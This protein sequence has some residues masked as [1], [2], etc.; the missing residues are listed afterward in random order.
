M[1]LLPEKNWDEPD[2]LADWAEVSALAGAE[3]TY[4]A[5][6]EDLKD[7]QL[8]QGTRQ[9]GSTD[10]EHT[11]ATARIWRAL[12]AR[13]K[14]YG[15]SWPF[16]LT[17]L[18][19]VASRDDA[20]YATLLLFDL[21]RCY[22]EAKIAPTHTER[23]LFEFVVEA[24]LR[25]LIRGAATRFGVPREGWP[26][27]GFRVS[28]G[29]LATHFQLAASDANVASLASTKQGDD[30]LDVVARLKLGDELPGTAYVLVQC[31]TGDDVLR[32][33]GDLSLDTWRKYIPWDAPALRALAVPWAARPRR[34][35][36]QRLSS[37]FDGAVILDR[38]RLVAGEPG[39]H[40]DDRHLKPLQRWCKR[41]IKALR[42]R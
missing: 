2:V 4:G 42:R 35:Q 21:A 18:A 34:E 16:E 17:R 12:G 39:R 29:Q 36:L 9:F 7:S 41:Q 24:S 27:G 8:F 15:G 38:W 5:I 28:V 1:L 14:E 37:K 26:R 23:K 22:G 10:P 33:A 20:A 19:L 32:K 6:M 3:C 30:G 13:Q 31:A 40:M 11:Q 25:S